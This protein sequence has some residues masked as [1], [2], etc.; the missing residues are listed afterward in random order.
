MAVDTALLDKWELH[1]WESGP[2]FSRTLSIA[3]QD[4]EHGLVTLTIDVFENNKAPALNVELT[5]GER[6]LL[7]VCDWL[8]GFKERDEDLVLRVSNFSAGPLTNAILALTISPKNGLLVSLER[9]ND[10]HS[11][12]DRNGE[13]LMIGRRQL[14]WFSSTDR[15]RLTLTNA[16]LG[17]KA[18]LAY[19][20]YPKEDKPCAIELGGG[21]VKTVIGPDPADRPG[22]ELE[23][24]FDPA[25]FLYETSRTNMDCRLDG[26]R[27]VVRFRNA[28]DE[29][30]GFTADA[31]SGR[32]LEFHFVEQG[33]HADLRF[34][35]GAFERQQAALYAAT[36][37]KARAV[38]G[39]QPLSSA[40]QALLEYPSWASWAANLSHLNP[41]AG[42]WTDAAQT[43]AK[44]FNAKTLGPLDQVLAR[45]AAVDKPDSFGVPLSI[46][47]VNHWDEHALGNSA[48]VFVFCTIEDFFPRD[49]WPW[50]LAREAAFV[51]QQKAQYTDAELQRLAQSKE[52]GPIG[53]L[54]LAS[55]L[56]DLNPQ[57]SKA[58]AGLGLNLL[59]AR[60]FR[61]DYRLLLDGQSALSQ[62]LQNVVSA[63][64]TLND[65]EVEALAQP[66]PSGVAGLIES[67]ARALRQSKRGVTLKTM[68]QNLGSDLG[69]LA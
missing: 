56:H 1:L 22:F 7:K 9:T 38:D 57:S 32:L 4:P 53:F 64:G 34:D 43:A 42:S 50:T 11:Q 63:L 2:F 67:T 35:S 10:T 13:H 44:L 21:F 28:S 54:A 46:G 26:D 59:G 45:R 55:V 6:A 36:A 69:S 5:E 39:H 31:R 49:S 18:T 66:F 41:A 15:A 40:I 58:A 23:T 51:M 33:V 30:N 17:T 29:G 3:P 47:D 37:A 65:A 52:T 48:A 68:Y 12:A 14:A 62:S 8:S 25:A 20:A 24:V 60:N 19:R 16:T 27:L 61:N